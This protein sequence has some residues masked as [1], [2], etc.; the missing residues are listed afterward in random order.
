MKRFLSL[1]T[2]LAILCVFSTSCNIT[3]ENTDSNIDD[4]LSAP[5]NRLLTAKLSARNLNTKVCYGQGYETD[6]SNRPIGA[7]NAQSDY[8]QYGALFIENEN[9]KVIYLTFDEGYENGYTESILD[10]LKEKK[11]KAT[12]Y[13]TLDYVKSSPDIVKRMIEEGHAVGNHTCNHPSLPDCSDEEIKAEIQTLEKYIESN[14]GG[15]KTTTVRPPKGEFSIRTADI[16]KQLG[17]KTVLWSFAYSDWD[18]NNQPDREKAYNRITGA[19][20]NGAIYL[21]HAVSK[22]NADILG[23]VID[24]W[25]NN[26][27]QIRA[28][29]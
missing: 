3:V 17:Y 7:I 16:A 5:E 2:A 20:H 22:T 11:V 19:T 4:S 24:Y 13:V 10:T 25:R 15:Y 1:A 27:Y 26:G 12:F 14:L 9:E 18:T 29:Q 8:G 23:E 28:V 6:D 21:L